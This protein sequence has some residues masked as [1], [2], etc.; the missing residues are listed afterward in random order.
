LERKIWKSWSEGS[1]SL[2]ARGLPNLALQDFRIKASRLFAPR[3]RHFL[4]QDFQTFRSTTSDRLIQTFRCKT[5]RPF[6]PKLTEFSLQ[7]FQTF[8]SKTSRLFRS[9]TSR[10]FDPRLPVA[11]RLP[12]LSLIPSFNPQSSGH[13]NN[14]I[15]EGVSVALSGNFVKAIL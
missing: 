10:P 1:G 14:L 6:A 4:L 12:P 2:G 5:Y 3:L 11:P 7:N 15:Q 9:K 8:R 13:I